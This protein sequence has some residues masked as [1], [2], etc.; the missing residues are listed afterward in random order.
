MRPWRPVFTGKMPSLQ[1]AIRFSITPGRM[2]RQHS[3][4]GATKRRLSAHALQSASR[5]LAET[6]FQKWLQNLHE[7][8][9][10]NTQPIQLPGA[11]SR[12][13]RPWRR[14]MR[15]RPDFLR[16]PRL[17][18]KNP[19]F[20]NATANAPAS[21]SAERREEFSFVSRRR[22]HLHHTQTGFQ[23]DA[24]V[25]SERASLHPNH[26]CSASINT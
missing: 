25:Q 19:N 20:P 1:G 15:R 23:R 6:D 13:P 18:T 17:T 22:R 7:F 4:P 9:R 10:V 21:W 2:R 3:K 16:L 11:V 14:R 8:V 5:G 26:R 24:S 12:P